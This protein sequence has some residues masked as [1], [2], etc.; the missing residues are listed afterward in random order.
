MTL[1]QCCC[2]VCMV[3]KLYPYKLWMR[4]EPHYRKAKITYCETPQNTAYPGDQGAFILLQNYHSN[5]F[6]KLKTWIKSFYYQ[7]SI[8]KEQT[9][10]YNQ[11]SRENLILFSLT[12]NKIVANIFN[13]VDNLK[14]LL[15]AQNSWLCYQPC[16]ISQSWPQ[17]YLEIH[18]HCWN[19]LF[20]KLDFIFHSSNMVK[21]GRLLWS[22]HFWQIQINSFF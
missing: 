8:K 6:Y 17:K 3:R 10:V 20:L 4:Q 16:R 9:V 21:K 11:I 13:S 7:N 18:I 2:I 22:L 12:E 1:L 14:I 19:T 15:P 5:I